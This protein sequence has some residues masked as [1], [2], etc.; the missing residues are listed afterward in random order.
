MQIRSVLLWDSIQRM[1]V[2]LIDVSEQPICTIF[3]GQEIQEDSTLRSV[4]SQRSADLKVI[5]V[6]YLYM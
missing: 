3:M 4:I 5:Y 6:Y 1:V 2:N